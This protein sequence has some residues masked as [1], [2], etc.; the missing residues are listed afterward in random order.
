LLQDILCW[1]ATTAH[2]HPLGPFFLSRHFENVV[3]LVVWACLPNVLR[4]C[5]DFMSSNRL[6]DFKRFW[7][8]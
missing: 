2:F 7:L 4:L 3:S 1:Y 6:Y 5:V 8:Q